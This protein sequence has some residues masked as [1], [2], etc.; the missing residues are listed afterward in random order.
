MIGASLIDDT[1][2]LP[3]LQH[4]LLINILFKV[5][6]YLK[7]KIRNKMIS[8]YILICFLTFLIK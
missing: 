4:M 7:Y 1:N 3:Q 2:L 5:E 6:R 8:I